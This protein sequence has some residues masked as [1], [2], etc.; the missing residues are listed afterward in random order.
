MTK[1][2]PRSHVRSASAPCALG[3]LR[4]PRLRETRRGLLPYHPINSDSGSA[5]PIWTPGRKR[6]YRYAIRSVQRFSR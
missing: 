5:R 1:H 2:I 6:N 3:R 4:R